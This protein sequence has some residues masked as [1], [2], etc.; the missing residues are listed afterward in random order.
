[1]QVIL[2]LWIQPI[3]TK[4]DSVCPGKEGK[5]G[6]QA[7]RSQQRLSQ[8]TG[9]KKKAATG[10]CWNPVFRSFSENHTRYVFRFLSFRKAA[11][12][13]FRS[14]PRPISAS[15]LHASLH[16]HPW[17][18]HLVVFK[19][20]YFSFR[21]GDLVLGPASCLDAFSSYPFPAWL[22]S[23][24][25]GMITG[26]PAAGPSRSSRTEDS[27]PQISDAHNR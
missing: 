19:G 13:F 9:Y 22:P 8:N 12:F 20:S 15:Q 25:I 21:M 24:T 11:G 26:A 7:N 23:S 5:H 1:M 16:F 2:S 10:D 17:S 4:R 6:P 18:I 14:S 3:L 27:F